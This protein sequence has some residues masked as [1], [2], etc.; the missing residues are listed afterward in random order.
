MRNLNMTLKDISK[1]IGLSES[2]ISQISHSLAERVIKIRKA[3]K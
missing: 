3:N 1:V 2:R